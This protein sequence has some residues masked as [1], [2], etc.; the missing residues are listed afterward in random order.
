[1]P[2]ENQAD[3]LTS[4]LVWRSGTM[5]EERYLV[6][7]PE[8][9]RDTQSI[10]KSILSLLTGVALDAGLLPGLDAPILP[11]LRIQPAEGEG[12]DLAEAVT[13][14]RWHQVTLRHVLTHTIGLP[15]EITDPDYDDA[16]WTSP[17]P[18]RFALSQP[19][20]DDPGTTWRYSNAGVQLL[21]E[22]LARAASEPLPEFAQRALFDPLGIAP[23][24][25]DTD[26]TG[27]PFGVLHLR[28]RD[29]L[30]LGQLVL[31][32][33]R[34][35]GRSLVPAAWVA[36]STTPQVPADPG[37]EGSAS[38]GHLWWTAPPYRGFFASGWGGQ[39]L[40]VAPDQEAVVV[41][42]GETRPHPSLRGLVESRL[43]GSPASS[44]R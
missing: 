34:W 26:P 32:Q 27:R 25:W 30:A 36:Q 31:A 4:V 9:L 24:L 6:G 43:G 40:A 18:L 12:G 1:M 42:T 11:L 8:D 23:P 2:L 3:G 33:G 44:S 16:W 28:T 29:L 7:G 19:L 41:V 13:D 17:D 10:G 39:Y 5:V 20:L 38:Y 15:S 21:G 37:M 22:L 14:P 35:E